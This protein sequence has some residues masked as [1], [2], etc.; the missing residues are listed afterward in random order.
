VLLPD[1]ARFLPEPTQFGEPPVDVTALYV[2]TPEYVVTSLDQDY[3]I[4][5]TDGHLVPTVVVSF[6]VPGLPGNFT[7]R[8]DNYAFTH[9]D[10]LEYMRERSWMLRGMYAIPETLPSWADVSGLS[11][12]AGTT[13]EAAAL[14]AAGQGL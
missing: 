8:I 13:L 14:A 7:I 6:V 12:Q 4:R 1:S 11:V 5:P 2:P 9:A 10:P 3:R